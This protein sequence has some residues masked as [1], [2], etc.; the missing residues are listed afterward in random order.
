MEGARWVEQGQAVDTI[1]AVKS[2]NQTARQSIKFLRPWFP[3]SDA[4]RLGSVIVPQ[5]TGTRFF[6]PVQCERQEGAHTA[7]GRGPTFPANFSRKQS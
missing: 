2:A 6:R 3:V 5:V 7:P 4:T 1:L